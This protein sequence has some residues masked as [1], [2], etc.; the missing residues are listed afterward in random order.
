MAAPWLTTEDVNWNLERAV[1]NILVDQQPAGIARP[2]S[3]DEVSEVVRSAAA[4]GKRVAV[5]RTGHNAAPLGSLANTVLLRTAGLGG[6]Q[7]DAAAATARVGAGALWAELV[8]KASGSGLGALHGSS[9]NVGIAGYTL[10][11]GVSFYGRQ[12]GL[13]CNRV[14]AIELVNG[15]G[16]QVRVDAENEPDLFWGL[17]GGGGSFGVVTALEFDLL[18]LREIFAGALFFRAEQASEVLHGWNEWTSGA[19]DEMTSVGRLLNFPPIPEIP[20]PFRGKSFAVL[21]AIYC[22]D[23][24]D[25]EG[26]VAPLRELGTVGMDTMAVQ[27][28]AGISELHMD[29]PDPVPYASASLLTSELPAAAIDSVLEAVGPGSGSQLLLIDLR[30]SAGA[31]SRAPQGA[32]ALAS[33]PGAFL[34]FGAGFVPVP[35]A[36]APTRAWL[37]AFK[38]ALEPYVAGNYLN[39]VEEPFD[40]TR[41]FPPEVLGRLREV[42]QRYDP[43][44]LFHSNH[45]VTG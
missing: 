25:G 15:R 38:A 30:H 32:G 1:F 31:L 17:R 7:I 3:A 27:P 37:G 19:P 16:E 42:K 18:P 43:E 23:P 4:D 21:E 28:P 2:R 39:F 5:Q 20:E 44:N 34:A 41:I 11:G 6:V 8:P 26:L 22:G 13:A 10:G 45:P 36:M 40:I 33:L 12:H 24:A 35:E 29:P 14:T 9:P